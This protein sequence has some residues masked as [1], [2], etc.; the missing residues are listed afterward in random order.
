M[1]PISLFIAAILFSSLTSLLNA[2]PSQPVDTL[3][4]EELRVIGTRIQ[5]P[6]H[7]QPVWIQSVDP[8][9]LRQL[10]HESAAYHLSGNT[11]SMVRDYGEGNMALVSQRGFSPVHTRVVWEEMPLN[12]PM[13]G[14]F[15]LSLV[16]AGLLD[17]ISSSSGNPAAM[18]GSGGI[19][20][21]LSMRT[22]THPDRFFL[23]RSVGSYGF[24]QTGL[25]ASL[26]KGSF[27]GGIRFYH[28][29]GDYD[30][31]FNDPDPMQQESLTREN[32]RK[33]STHL[34]AHGY[35]RHDDWHFRSLVWL[36]D[37]ANDLPG[38]VFFPMPARQDDRS[39]RVLVQTGYDGWKRT[40]FTATAGWYYY[41]LD[42]SDQFTDPADGS[43]ATLYLIQPA[44]RH[45][46]SRHHESHLSA[47]WAIQSVEANTYPENKQ[48]QNLSIRWNHAW[49]ALQTLVLYPSVEWEWHSLFND[50]LN[51]A[52][53]I[54]FHP[55]TDHVMLRGMAGRNRNNPTYNDMY[56]EPFGNPGLKPETVFTYEAG[57]TVTFGR[58]KSSQGGNRNHRVASPVELPVSTGQEY[59]RAGAAAVMASGPAQVTTNQSGGTLVAGITLFRHDFDNGIRWIPGEDGMFAPEN[60]EDIRSQGIELSIRAAQTLGFLRLDVLYLLT[61]TDASVRQE[62]FPGDGSVGRQMVYVPEW[63]HKGMLQINIKSRFWSRLSV[64]D[65]GERFTT[66]DHSSPRD[67]LAAYTRMDF[68]TGWDFNLRSVTLRTSIGIRNL[69]SER[70]EVISGYPV[71]PRHYRASLTMTLK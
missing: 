30:F 18:S 16:P 45:A 42:Y 32:N 52:L 2:A 64:Q 68:D 35:Y 49:Q 56:W 48:H 41:E 24:G 55:A 63:T 60:V 57:A 22:H 50:A 1:L 59:S 25:G 12:H 39:A 46:W 69:T 7:R 33:A 17:G 71:A 5:V 10:P 28:Q 53:G 44:V 67:P 47:Q 61:R 11:F 13:L 34:L 37:T 26:R 58:R 31:P 65:T 70:Y 4:L 54:T 29:K 40:W 51:P 15:D 36:D 27:D 19:G 38:S 62:R 14:M 20:G 43:T 66:M 9:L 6:D 8:Q 21:I 23:T 3:Y